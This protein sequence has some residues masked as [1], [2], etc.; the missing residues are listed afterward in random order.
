MED[1]SNSINQLDIISIY[2]ALHP[3]TDN[4]F[5]SSAHETFTK[6][7]C[8]LGHKTNIHKFK[9]IKIIQR[10]FCDHNRI[11]NKLKTE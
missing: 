2:R 11:K 8:I 5:S 3:T 1:L 4:T 7:H 10:K 9:K 6:I